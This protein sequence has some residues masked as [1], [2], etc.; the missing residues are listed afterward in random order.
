MNLIHPMCRIPL[1]LTCLIDIWQPLSSMHNLAFSS[2]CQSPQ[3]DFSSCRAYTVTVPAC[4]GDSV[5]VPPAVCDSHPSVCRFRSP[6]ACRVQQVAASSSAGAGLGERREATRG[7]RGEATTTE[8]EPSTTTPRARGSTHRMAASA[9]A[10][11]LSTPFDRSNPSLP[12]D[13]IWS[14][15]GRRAGLE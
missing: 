10:D 9:T 7:E 3:G 4:G 15:R 6:V 11:P 5:R 1:Y 14:V 13:R 12:A 2:F 8:H